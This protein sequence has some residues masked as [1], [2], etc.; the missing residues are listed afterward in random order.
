MNELVFYVIY[1]FC[2]FALDPAC[3]SHCFV[4]RGL[5][6]LHEGDGRPFT[7][8]VAAAASTVVVAGGEDGTARET[9][10]AMEL[11][12][13]TA[14]VSRLEASLERV[15]AAL[16]GAAVAGTRTPAGGT[17]VGDDSGVVVVDSRNSSS[18]SSSSEASSE[19]EL[20]DGTKRLAVDADS[21]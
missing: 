4:H 19:G 8:P 3:P 6:A 11:R 21:S 14:Q 1:C 16:P 5:K 20:P 15:L 7:E 18:G 13:L 9:S 17:G 10:V 12:A 2:L